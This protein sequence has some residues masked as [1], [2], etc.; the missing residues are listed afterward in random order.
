MALQRTSKP[1]VSVIVRTM[2]KVTTTYRL[3]Y[4]TEEFLGRERWNVVETRGCRN[5]L[6]AI[7]QL[8]GEA[9]SV[10]RT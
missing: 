6:A 3:V 1:F 2:R 9:S 5:D 4:V 8:C 7:N 10:T